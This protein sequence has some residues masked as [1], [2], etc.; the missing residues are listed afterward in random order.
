MNN[1]NGFTPRQHD[2][3]DD[4]SPRTQHSPGHRS[5]TRQRRGVLAALVAVTTVTGVALTGCGKSGGADGAGKADATE[6]V[7]KSKKVLWMGD[8]I[9]GAEAPPL[10]AALKASGVAFKNAASDGGGTVVEGDKMAA[11]IAADTWKDVAKNVGAFHPD[12]IAY[13]ITTYDWGTQDQQRAS[14]EKLAKTAE[15]A[16]AELVLVSAPPFKIDDFYK[17]YEGAIASAPKAAKEVAD[18]SGGK[19]RFLDAS[20]LW[21]T[22]AKG[23]KAQRASDGIHSCQQ[24]SAAFAKWFTDQL[25]RAYG[26]TPA[27]PEKWANG[28]W[29]GDAR[30][31]KLGC[32]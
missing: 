23:G 21:G 20:A 3:A 10:E 24:G 12:V 29:T 18:R 1:D 9:A 22:D 6:A 8:S 15:Q 25:G 26:F 7:Q 28:S 11:P 30:Y 16:G 5:R 17:K 4:Q 27:T 19:V 13:Q 14:Y 31:G 32:R 2:H